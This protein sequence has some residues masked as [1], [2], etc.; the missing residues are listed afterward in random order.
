M[1][2]MRFQF[3][4]RLAGFTIVEILIVIVVIGILAALTISYYSGS[5]EAAYLARGKSDLE[6]IGNAA[7]LYVNKNDTYPPDESRDIPAAIKEFIATD[8]Q[9]SDWPKAPW[10]GSVFDYESWNIDGDAGDETIQISIRFCE[11]GAPATCKFPKESWA[12]GFGVDS[13]FYYCIKGYCRSHR[14]QPVTYPGYCYN[15]SDHGPVKLP[16]E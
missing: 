16:T 4:N 11:A 12:A 13:A 15:C 5:R 8:A 7:R 3:K 9:G 14:D 2:H 6:S 1:K 10:P